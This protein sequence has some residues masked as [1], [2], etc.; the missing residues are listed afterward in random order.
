M[1]REPE[2]ELSNIVPE[3]NKN[4]SSPYL[5]SSPATSV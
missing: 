5:A 3:L 1:V 4:H 2:S